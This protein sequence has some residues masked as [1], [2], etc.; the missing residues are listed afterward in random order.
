LS[1]PPGQDV[2]EVLRMV[3][4]DLHSGYVLTYELPEQNIRQHS[5]RILPS[6]DPKLQFRSRQ[7]YDAYE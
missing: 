7:A 6:S 1:F 3:L 2:P 5:V 4:A